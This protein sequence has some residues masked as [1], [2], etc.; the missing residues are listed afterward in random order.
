LAMST[1]ML[2]PCSAA[3]PAHGTHA[4]TPASRASCSHLP[5][6]PHLRGGG[7]LR[8]PFG[9]G[10]GGG[11]G[12]KESK[13][14]V[15]EPVGKSEKLNYAKSGALLGSAVVSTIALEMISDWMYVEVLFGIQV[16]W[17]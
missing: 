7:G 2:L 1:A 3:L 15:V 11:G 14:Q 13:K 8:L 6:M 17:P 16:C 5:A 9:G 10:G 12:G 4:N